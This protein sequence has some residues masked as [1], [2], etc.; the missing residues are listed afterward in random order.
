MNL[1][2]GELI[3]YA[4]F[5]GLPGKVKGELWVGIGDAVRVP[6]LLCFVCWWA[7]LLMVLCAYR[8]FSFP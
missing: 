4:M 1:S 7:M 2:S 8:F 6:R 5:F 3:V